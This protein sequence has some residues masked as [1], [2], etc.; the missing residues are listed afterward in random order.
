MKYGLIGA[1]LGVG[2]A[3]VLPTWLTVVGC[4]GLTLWIIKEV[5]A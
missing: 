4:I 1:I 2:L 5:G 3:A